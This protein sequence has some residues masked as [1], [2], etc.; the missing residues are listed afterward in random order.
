MR[1]FRKDRKSEIIEHRTRSPGPSGL[2]ADFG[3]LLEYL[4][5]CRLLL[6]EMEVKRGAG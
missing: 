2:R 6:R 3:L 4:T 5:E 1:D